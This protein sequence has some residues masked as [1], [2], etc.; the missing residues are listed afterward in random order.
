[1]EKGPQ[2]YPNPE[3]TFIITIDIVDLSLFVVFSLS[4]FS[5]ISIV[6]VIDFSVI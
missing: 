5:R 4:R 6:F 1:M 2:V 3:N